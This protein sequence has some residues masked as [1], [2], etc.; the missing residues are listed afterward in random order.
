MRTVTPFW[1]RG[2]SPGCTDLSRDTFVE[3]SQPAG[4]PGYKEVHSKGGDD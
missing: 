4:T 2:V 3:E 1:G